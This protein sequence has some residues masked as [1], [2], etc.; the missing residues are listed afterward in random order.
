M[1]GAPLAVPLSSP[2]S[3]ENQPWLS[4]SASAPAWRATFVGAFVLLC[5]PLLVVD[6]P[7]L[8]DYANHMA[9]VDILAH[10]GDDPFL[11]QVY[12]TK[13]EIIPDLAIDSFMPL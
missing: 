10:L 11:S 4:T 7:P 6:V 12:K 5:L 8:T 3:P 2:A 9:R 1:I 13:W